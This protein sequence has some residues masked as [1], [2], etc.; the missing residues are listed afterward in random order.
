[1][2]YVIL[3]YRGSPDDVVGVAAMRDASQA[4][5]F[6]LR[7]KRAA[8]HEGLIVSVAD[9]PFVHCVPRTR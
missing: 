7:W 4:V 5:E 9:Q 2:D 6:A 3:R 8:P 1:M